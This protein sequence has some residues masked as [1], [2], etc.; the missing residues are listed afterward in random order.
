VGLESTIVD[1]SSGQPAILRP[2]AVTAEQIAAAL[3]T[4]L[5]APAVGAPRVS[6]SLPSHYAP[7]ARV[8]IVTSEL[9]WQRAREL[10]AQGESV[11]VLAHGAPAVADPAL[12]VLEIPPSAADF[13][14]ELYALPA[15]R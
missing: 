6:G 11:A 10:A 4:E 2:G 7:Q 13:G 12:V 8:E 1:V 5:S 3:K 9:L 15:G 14:R